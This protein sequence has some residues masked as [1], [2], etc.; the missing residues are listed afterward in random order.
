MSIFTNGQEIFIWLWS[1]TNGAVRYI[2]ATALG[3]TTMYGPPGDEE[4]SEVVQ[5]EVGLYNEIKSVYGE[6]DHFNDPDGKMPCP[7]VIEGD[8]D[9]TFCV[10][11]GAPE[12]GLPWTLADAQAGITGAPPVQEPGGDPEPEEDPT[13]DPEYAIGST[14]YF[15]FNKGVEE[16]VVMVHLPAT[17]VEGDGEDHGGKLAFALADPAAFLTAHGHDLQSGYAYFMASQTAVEISDSGAAVFYGI[18]KDAP[19]APCLCELAG[20]ALWDGSHL[21][22]GTD[23]DPEEPP[24]ED[25]P[26]EDPP[27]EPALW[28]E[29][30]DLDSQKIQFIA[31]YLN[32]HG[33]DIDVVAEL[34]ADLFDWELP[35]G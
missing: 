2:P 17:V 14:L 20:G 32:E 25:P 12:G 7:C 15:H 13:G 23:M 5:I 3:E 21:V 27:A 10:S 16:G 24:V 6:I 34:M 35:L 31:D 26:V 9:N 4:E 33:G 30:M 28:A 11:P 22:P 19:E 1:D 29:H 18:M 8:D